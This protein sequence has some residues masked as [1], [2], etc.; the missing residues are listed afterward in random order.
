M[1][2]GLLE[3]LGILEGEGKGWKTLIYQPSNSNP[4]SFHIPPES[5]PSHKSMKTMQCAFNYTKQISLL[6]EK[7]NTVKYLDQEKHQLKYQR[8][9][10][11][12]KFLKR[13]YHKKEPRQFCVSSYMRTIE[14]LAKIVRK[15]RSFWIKKI[16]RKLKKYYK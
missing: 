9:V 6:G 13:R 8:I 3:V 10:Q 5:T 2:K 4:Q 1:G 16:K 14:L 7:L 11:L 12:Q 15:K